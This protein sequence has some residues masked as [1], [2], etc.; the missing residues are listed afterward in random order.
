[1]K[2]VEILLIEE[3]GGVDSFDEVLW[4]VL[5]NRHKVLL[6]ELNVK[7]AING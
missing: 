2:L 4:L 5:G 3:V 7:E 6:F 1:M